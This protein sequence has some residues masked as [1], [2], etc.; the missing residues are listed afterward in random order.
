MKTEPKKFYVKCIEDFSTQNSKGE[1][2]NEVYCNEE[3]KV[4]L[5]EKTD[6]YFTRDS[7]N[8]EVNV[9]FRDKTGLV[10]IDESFRRLPISQQKFNYI[11]TIR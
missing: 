1:T 4:T 11:Y 6:E 5:N 3:F 7:Q 8:R 2:V 9:G 10:H